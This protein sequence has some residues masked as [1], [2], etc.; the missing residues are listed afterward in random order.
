[1]D[2]EGNSPYQKGVI[3]EIC[4]RPEKSYFQVPPE[5]QGL[6][7]TGKLVQ[8]FLP[9]QADIDKILKIIQRKF[10]KVTHLPVTLKEI[11]E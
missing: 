6:V 9:R 8:R 11:Q 7:S 1:M 5:M 2:F 3:S 10:L 4:Q